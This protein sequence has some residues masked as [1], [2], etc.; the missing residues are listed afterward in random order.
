MRIVVR[1]F[2]IAAVVCSL[3]VP[4]WAVTAQD[5]VKLHV[6]GLSD[7]ILIALI[8]SD[9][10]TFK[11]TAD[12]IIA[13][14]QQGLSERIIRTML[15]AGKKVTTP[16]PAPE[17]MVEAPSVPLYELTQP[18]AVPATPV[19]PVVNVTQQVEQNVELPR[20]NAYNPYGQYPYVPYYPVYVAVPFTVQPAAVKR[21]EPVYWGYGGQRRP[22]AWQ[23]R[24]DR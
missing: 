5:L 20:S 17:R 9:G 4:A 11:L 23:P 16:A 3:A 21:P 19:A 2:V 6:A 12:E 13:L 15:L 1:L 24:R 22:D 18:P 14:R 10:S 7:D 8:E